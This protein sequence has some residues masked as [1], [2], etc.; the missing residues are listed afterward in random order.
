MNKKEGNK[1]SKLAIVGMDCYLG[2]CKDL[3]TFE[4]SI[5]DGN[6]HFIDIPPQRWQILE[7]QK[8]YGLNLTGAARGAYIRD[9]EIEVSELQLTREQIE[10][11]QLQELLILKVITRALKNVNFYKKSRVAIVIVAPTE[12]FKN[13]EKPDSV[14]NLW[15]ISNP[16]FSLTV[17]VQENSAF[18][19]LEVA[20]KLLVVKEVDVVVVSA[21]ELAGNSLSVLL[22]SQKAKIN[23]GIN[24]LSYDQNVNGWMVGEG[25]AAVVLKL[26]ET[27][28]QDS[29]RIY[30]VIDA[31]SIIKQ[32]SST[33]LPSR[34]IA[35]VCH[36]AFD[37]AGIKPADI[38]YLEVFGSGIPQED[39]SEIQGLLQAYRTGC[40]PN[41]TCAIG[42]VKAN[43]GHTYAASGIVSLIKTALC[44]YHRYIPAVPQW[45]APK[46]PHIWDGS[47]F[48]VP[49]ESKPSFLE[50]G[51]SKRI[52]AINSI[53]ID[54]SYAHLILSE[55]PTQIQRHSRYLEQMPFYLF[56]IAANDCPT[57]LEQLHTLQQ[58]I[59]DSSYCLSTTA[60]LTYNTF[61]QHENA[62]YALAILGRNQQEL[63]QEI[64][65][66]FKGVASAFDTGSDWQTPRGSYFTPNPQARKGTVAF[67][68]PA[69][70]NSYIGIARNLFRLFPK[71]YDDPVIASVYNRVANVEKSI[72]PRSLSKLSKK[73]L[74][75]LEQRLIDDPIAMLESEMG[76]A[77]LLSAI[78]KNYFH[79]EPQC[80]FG[81][82]LGETSMI[83]AQGVWTYFHEG[84]EGLNSSTLFKTQLSGPKNAVR[85]YWGLPLQESY[86]GEDFWS[87][88]ILLCPVS[89]VR[90]VLKQENRVYLILINT[91]E[92]VAIAGDPEA[93][94]RVIQTL[95]CDAFRAP[96]NHVIHCE[97]IR[98]EYDE[99]VKLNTLPVQN[100]P[101]ITFYS[102]AEYQPITINS[103]SIANNIAKALCQ[104]ID[105]PRLISRV[106]QDSARIFVEVGAGSHCSRW[107][108]KILKQKEHLAV[109]LNHRGTDEYTSIIK[110]LAKLVSHRIKMDLS[111]LYFQV[112]ENSK[113]NHAV[114]K[115]ITL[116]SSEYDSTFLNQQDKKKF[117]LPSPDSL[118]ES[119]KKQQLESTVKFQATQ[120]FN[121]LN[122]RKPLYQ[123]LTENTLR[124]TQNH[125]NF[126]QDREQSLQEISKIIQLQL[127]CLQQIFGKNSSTP[128]S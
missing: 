46:E 23:T 42:S 15:S 102:A 92:E 75:A 7:K 4:R 105:F 60:S 128:T 115:T 9:L 100:I 127:T 78:M 112:P 61:Q 119:I 29:D 68:Y 57:L 126:L 10:N 5:Y 84:S 109:S 88:Y 73:Q 11:C 38:S 41:L 77:G 52:A 62:T 50:K 89:R 90:E 74:E 117:Q 70:Y 53:E 34:A 1:N 56:A 48:Y 16:S 45:T 66:A 43:F 18:Q 96:F 51:A 19:A 116:D 28:Q 47:P 63:I 32:N 93:C 71:I 104:H 59:T 125:A 26:G 103:Y 106:W 87:T 86:E 17:T 64:Q 40:E 80:A 65:R 72:Y 79:I 113:P 8:I 118:L 95:N 25:A 111:S 2:G 76:V 12:L 33:V 97:A 124:L 67:V 35:Q 27:A 3:D 83:L 36:Q 123:K 82:S 54:G 58:R 121:V 94:Q 81:Y 49:I 21:V 37:L 30:A 55:E 31:L 22:R 98:S 110:A 24:T 85:K 122:L 107:I 91:P 101:N 6:Q 69:A 44:L 108:S 99:L 20:Q 14:F 39:E 114:I 120:K 13:Q